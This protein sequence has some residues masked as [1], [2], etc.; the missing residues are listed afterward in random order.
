MRVTLKAD[1]DCK[2]CKGRGIYVVTEV[3][4]H[5]GWDIRLHACKCVKAVFHGRTKQE[6]IRALVLDA[7]SGDRTKEPAAM[8]KLN[9]HEVGEPREGRNG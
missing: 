9:W 5:P 8:K 7:L 2:Q 1:S 4:L 3:G 6:Q